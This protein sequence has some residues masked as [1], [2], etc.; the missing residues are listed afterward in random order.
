MLSRKHISLTFI[1]LGI[2]F[3]KILRMLLR[4]FLPLT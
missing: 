2:L 3:T 4:N 1:S